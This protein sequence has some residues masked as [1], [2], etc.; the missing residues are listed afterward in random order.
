ME[1]YKYL[2]R[3]LYLRLCFFIKVSRVSFQV[4]NFVPVVDS[5]R[6]VFSRTYRNRGGPRAETLMALIMDI[7]S[8]LVVFTVAEIRLEEDNIMSAGSYAYFSVAVAT[9]QPLY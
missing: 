1:I 9:P 7:V 5:L 2:P 6:D 3:A 8:V 4:S